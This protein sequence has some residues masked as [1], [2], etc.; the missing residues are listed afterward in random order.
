MVDVGVNVGVEVFVGVLEET[1]WVVVSG[2]EAAAEGL[3]F[4]ESIFSKSAPTPPSKTSSK[5]LARSAM[6]LQ[7]FLPAEA[8]EPLVLGRVVSEDGGSETRLG[9][10]VLDR[11]VAGS[12]TAWVSAAAKA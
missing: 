12:C 8:F 4:V 7:P 11:L 9:I 2:R 6:P 5:T 10:N 1:T 3:L